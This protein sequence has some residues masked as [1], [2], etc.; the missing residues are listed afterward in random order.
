MHQVGYKATPNHS[1]LKV[2][3]NMDSEDSEVRR[4]L[5]RSICVILERRETEAR[6]EVESETE[7]RRE[8]EGDAE[9]RVEE[10]GKTAKFITRA[11]GGSR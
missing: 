10:E 4:E 11:A 8:R 7:A 3:K 2:A 1:N 9:A 6:R 5:G